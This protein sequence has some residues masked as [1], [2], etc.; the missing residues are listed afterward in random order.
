MNIEKAFARQKQSWIF[1]EMLVCLAIIGF[2]DFRTSY[3]F[4][5]LPFYAGPIFV[6]AWFCGKKPGVLMALLSVLVW[7]CA[8]WFGGDP[9]LRSWIWMWEISRH[10][11]SFLVVSWIAS[12]LRAKSDMAAARIALLEHSQRLE[13]EIVNV[14]ESEQR[15]IGQDLHDGLCQYLAALNCSAASLR[16]DLK[17]LNL[18]THAETAGELA[19][20][21]QEAVVETRDL[22]RELVPAHISESGL[23]VA[24]ESLAQS[25]TRLQGINCTFRR[26]GPRANCSEQTAMHLYRIAQEAINNATK[27]GKARKIDIVLVTEDDPLTLRITDNGAGI[28]ESGS[29]GMGL[30][31]MRYRARLSG[32]ELKIERPKSG[33]TVIYCTAR[34]RPSNK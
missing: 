22:S 10:L 4:R 16:D 6:V 21:L 14:S 34:N 12:I 13:H 19:K 32:G 33:G 29:N 7:W 11:G 25:V 9:E 18:P 17:K 23:G 31:I 30:A 5:L 28:S 3:Q 8:N 26:D 24:L 2:F 20:H 1:A 15:R 27:H